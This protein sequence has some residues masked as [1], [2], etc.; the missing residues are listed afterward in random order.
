MSYKLTIIVPLAF[1]NCFLSYSQN[2]KIIKKEKSIV[3]DSTII[4]IHK[5]N[6]TMIK[7]LKNIEFL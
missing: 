6:S 2:G 4:R 1:F 7:A 3:S 5:A